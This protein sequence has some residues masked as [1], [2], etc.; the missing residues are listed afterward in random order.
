M[1]SAIELL[2]VKPA[3][4]GEFARR[5]Q[6]SFTKAARDAF[7][8]FHE[9]IPPD[10][11]IQEALGAPGAEALHLLHDGS[12]VGG[13][14]VSGDGEEKFLEFIFIDPELQDRHLGLL[15]WQAIEAH[16]PKA[17]AWELVTPYHERRNI[18]FYVNKC[19]FHIVEYFNDHHPDPSYS[20]EEGADYP[21]ADGGLFRFRKV[22]DTDKD[23]S[24]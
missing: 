16:Y 17:Q 3:E 24:S 19:G 8:D 13:A 23:Q 7:P 22:V 14:V 6:V 2:P 1:E 10:R 21:G 4:M 5:M 11:D 15:A 20:Q 9:V 12:P 18:H